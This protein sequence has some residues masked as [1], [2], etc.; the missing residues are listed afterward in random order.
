MEMLAA[1]LAGAFG[2]AVVRGR[3]VPLVVATVLG[4]CGGGAGWY[5]LGLLG[6]GLR[7]GPLVLLHMAAGA[8]LG[9]APVFA[10][11]LVWRRA[12]G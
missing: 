3:S 7:A 4:I 9:A 1:M 12:G 8:T 6:P 10:A 5:L 2:G 11:G